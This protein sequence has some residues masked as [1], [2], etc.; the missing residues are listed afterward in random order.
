MDASRL[1]SEPVGQNKKKSIRERKLLRKAVKIPLPQSDDADLILHNCE[2]DV[3]PP[4]AMPVSKCANPSGPQ[5]T[6]IVYGES[7]FSAVHPTQESEDRSEEAAGYIS[8]AIELASEMEVEEVPS[9]TFY[10]PFQDES[11]SLLERV[12]AFNRFE[13]ELKAPLLQWRKT[14]GE[15]PTCM[16]CGEKHPL[17]CRSQAERGRLAYAFKE[18]KKLRA[19]LFSVNMGPPTLPHREMLETLGPNG[20]KEI[21]MG[22][23]FNGFTTMSSKPVFCR[24]CA[25]RH[26]GGAKECKT[27]FCTKGCNLNHPPPEPCAAA[28]KR[29]KSRMP[30]EAK[31]GEEKEKERAWKKEEETPMPVPTPAETGFGSEFGKFGTFFHSMEKAAGELFAGM[32]PK[33]PA[34][35]PAEKPG[36][37]H[38]KRRKRRKK[39]T[40]GG[41]SCQ[42][43][44]PAPQGPKGPSGDGGQGAQSAFGSVYSIR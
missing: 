4:G 25:R 42:N 20:S 16:E 28:I 5:E 27:P 36:S 9:R 11:L 31:D 7:R 40:G 41:N 15:K 33:R 29:F 12:S 13:W 2:Q 26:P 17:P 22:G 23:S 19:E 43:T 6:Q 32:T 21:H 1:P 38:K 30:A 34:P 44:E 8:N 10:H 37:E 39:R 24:I 35:E 14:E 3:A 18:G